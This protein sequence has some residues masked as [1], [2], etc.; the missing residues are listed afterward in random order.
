MLPWKSLLTSGLA[1]Y[2]RVAGQAIHQTD[3]K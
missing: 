3:S 2:G 1:A